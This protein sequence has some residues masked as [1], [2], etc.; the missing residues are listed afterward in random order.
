MKSRYLYIV[1]C[2]FATLFACDKNSILPEPDIQQGDALVFNFTRGAGDYIEAPDGDYGLFAVEHA[3]S[4]SLA[5]LWSSITSGSFYSNIENR[6]GIKSGDKLTFIDGADGKPCRYPSNDSLSVFLYH[7]YIAGVTPQ[8]IPVG[9]AP[10]KYPDFLAGRK[11]ISVVAGTPEEAVPNNTVVPIRHLMARVHFQIKNPGVESLVLNRVT[12]GGITWRG[13][14]NPQ[15]KTSVGFFTPADGESPEDLEL[16][17]SEVSIQGTPMGQAVISQ[18]IPIDPQYN[19][20]NTEAGATTGAYYDRDSEYN[21]YLLVPPLAEADLNEVS[22]TVTVS[23]SSTTTQTYEMR[24]TAITSWEPGKS[25][26][27]TI[28]FSAF[29]I[30]EFFGNIEP[31]QEELYIGETDLIPLVNP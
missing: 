30:L 17:G 10:H 27:Y 7:P 3:T 13:T 16:I 6:K 9:R 29:P 19:Y 21:Y 5:I 25:Y 20:S 12:L 28:N 23:R 8:S 4:G 14:I 22:L 26:C 11:A 2:L 1:I 15:I 31:W 18:Y 24:Q